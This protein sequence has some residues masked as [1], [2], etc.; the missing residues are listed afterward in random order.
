M[1]DSIT[2]LRSNLSS[3]ISSFG[4]PGRARS[5]ISLRLRNSENRVNNYLPCK[6]VVSL[7]DDICEGF[8]YNRPSEL[9][10]MILIGKEAEISS[11][12]KRKGA[13]A[14]LGWEGHIDK[15]WMDGQCPSPLLALP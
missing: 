8:V 7:R 15:D 11:G 13:S 6:E 4:V 10:T 3:A 5:I 12:G 9:V 1:P 2:G 14:L